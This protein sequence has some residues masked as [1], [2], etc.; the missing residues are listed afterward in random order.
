[1]VDELLVSPLLL[2]DCDV[3]QGG[4]KVHDLLH[5]RPRRLLGAA[6]ENPQLRQEVEVCRQ[7]LQSP[8]M[9]WGDKVCVYV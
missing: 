4:F 1:M 5:Q 6:K 2:R 3:G 9:G 8:G 7:I